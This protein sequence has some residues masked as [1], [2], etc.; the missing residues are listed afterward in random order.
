M[1]EA[2]SAWERDAERSSLFREAMLLLSMEEW[3]HA[4]R[5]ELF[6]L[7]KAIV[8]QEEWEESADRSELFDICWN[9]A[10]QEEWE[11]SA[12]RSELFD[13]CWNI[14]EQEEWE[15]S[16]DRS[17]L[18]QE[19]C[20]VTSVYP[21]ADA[22]L[23][24]DDGSARSSSPEADH[25]PLPPLW[26]RSEF[27]VKSAVLS[28]GLAPLT[29]VVVEEALSVAV[30]PEVQP[31]DVCADTLDKSG[32]MWSPNNVASMFEAWSLPPSL[33]LGAA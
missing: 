15:E 25:L 16:A 3:E 32:K 10:E 18:F 28:A 27:K 23:I 19:L 22:E 14:A 6:Q 21:M 26:S 1:E 7:A 29:S 33:D 30:S 20:R 9:I 11:E 31:R 4:G 8:E 2:Q 13:I 17:E 24:S 5:S 12:D